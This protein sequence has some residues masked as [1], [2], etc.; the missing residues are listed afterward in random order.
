MAQRR[1]AKCSPQ[2]CVS[3]QLFR[4]SGGTTTSIIGELPRTAKW[5]GL[6][7]L[8]S[9]VS[10]R[11]PGLL[12]TGEDAGVVKLA[13][14]EQRAAVANDALRLAEEELQTS[15]SRIWIESRRLL[16]APG[17]SVEV[18]IE[19]SDRTSKSSFVRGDRLADIAEDAVDFPASIRIERQPRIGGN[20]RTK[21]TLRQRLEA[22]KG[23][24]DLLIS[25]GEGFIRG[26][27]PQHSQS[28]SVHLVDRLDRSQRLHPERIPAAIPSQ[29]ALPGNVVQRRRIPGDPVDPPRMGLA[30]DKIPLRYVAGGTGSLAVSRDAGVLEQKRAQFNRRWIIVVAIGPVDRCS[31]P[32]Q[33][34][35]LTAC[36]LIEQHIG[37]R[38]WILQRQHRTQRPEQ[39]HFHRISTQ[40]RARSRWG[41]S[42]TSTVNSQRPPMWNRTP[43]ASK[44]PSGRR[45]V[46][47]GT[48]NPWACCGIPPSK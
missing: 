4:S 8:D 44:P 32:L 14:G 11:I 33:R 43:C 9:A 41:P 5:I 42:S 36:H 35:R 18:R 39:D 19:G 12:A 34:H 15:S 1:C 22:R 27:I 25:F 40:V 29:P 28:I 17:Q 30:I 16:I 46:T 48:A 13:I 31:D 24:E 47:T 6:Q 37:F 2:S 23:T 20:P 3:A 38:N 26:E 21:G 7:L 10:T 45:V